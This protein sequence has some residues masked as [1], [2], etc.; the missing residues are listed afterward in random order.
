MDERFRIRIPRLRV[1]TDDKRELIHLSTLEVMRRTGISVK[2]EKA[3][4]I[5]KK[6]GCYVE[7][8]MVRI[9]AHLVEWALRNT[10]PRL[11]LCNRQGEPALFLEK[12]NA[13]FGTGSD[14]PNILDPYT[15]QRRP[16]VL[17]DIE[18]VSKVVDYLPELGFIMCAG[19]ASDVN[20]T[21]S[22]LYHFDAMVNNT[23]KPIVFTAWS[24]DNLK[25][26]IE[27]AELVAGGTAELRNN[28]F[29]AL[30]TE[31]ISPLTLAAESAQKLMFMAEKSLPVVFTPGLLTGATGPVTIAGGLIQANAEMLSGYVLANLIREGVP[32]VYGGGVLPLDM[33]VSLMS[34]ASPEFMLAT[35]AF[36][37]MARYYSLPMF[38]FAGC[39]DSNS[40]DQ[41]ATLEGSLWILLSSLNGGNLIHDV[42]Y[43]NNGLT[44]AFEQI[45]VSN[46]VI[47]MVRH[48][49][50]GIE[51]NEDT[52]ALDLIDEIGPGG[53]FL[54]CEHTLKHFRDNFYPEL[55]TR[56]TYEKWENEGRKD[57]GTRA[58]EKARYILEQYKPR[59]L[60][61]KLRTELN[62]IIK[63]MDR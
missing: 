1:L 30:Y 56:E 58:N 45:V 20:S 14:T 55:I 21:I 8:N 27:M 61:D 57:L 28:P 23:E 33:R 19:I 54:T 12:N 18:N 46:E 41:Q 49:T 39:S 11:A 47:G 16:A 53:E 10:P 6:G 4:G 35:S 62:K 13:Y 9:P 22:D 26:I 3:L 40:F 7:G 63:A 44:T 17:K 34:Y 36:T 5:F 31:P 43:I 48:I 42:G 59:I 38:S 24:L 32:F 29:I 2:D 51:F 52:M 25:A 50:R 37:D 60:E 15:N